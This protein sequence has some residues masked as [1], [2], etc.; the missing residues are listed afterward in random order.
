LGMANVN[1]ENLPHLKIAKLVGS[2]LKP[3]LSPQESFHNQSAIRL[4]VS[5]KF[6]ELLEKSYD[7]SLWTTIIDPKVTLSFFRNSKD[8]LLIHYSDQYTSSSGYDA[9]T[10]TKRAD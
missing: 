9:I 6:K 3:S 10:V 7:S 1:K 8:M 5:S 2:L 4:A